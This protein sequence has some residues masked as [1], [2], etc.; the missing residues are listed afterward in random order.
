VHY[1]PSVYSQKSLEGWLTGPRATFAL[2]LFAFYPSRFLY[3][4]KVQQHSLWQEGLRTGKTGAVSS[5]V[6]E[7]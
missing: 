6:R 2:P 1:S 3:T 7:R 5:Q 4:T